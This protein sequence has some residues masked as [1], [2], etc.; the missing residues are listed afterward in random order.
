MSFSVSSCMSCIC[1]T[2]PLAEAFLRASNDSATD[3]T[4]TETEVGTSERISSVGE[5][6]GS[7]GK[8]DGLEDM[9]LAIS[10][11]KFSNLFHSS[12]RFTE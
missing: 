4:G 6:E 7:G 5:K 1:S 9:N 8:V 10:I 12:N 2:T 3:L 11:L